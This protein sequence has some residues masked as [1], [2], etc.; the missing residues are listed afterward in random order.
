MGAPSPQR[1]YH[2]L[3]IIFNRPSGRLLIHLTIIPFFL[4]GDPSLQMIM[5]YQYFLLDRAAI[6]ENI[7][8]TFY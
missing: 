6:Y 5:F 7:L 2:V 4:V 8:T 3:S 1:D